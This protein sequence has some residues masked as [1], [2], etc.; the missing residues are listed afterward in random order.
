[1]ISFGSLLRNRH[2]PARRSIANLPHFHATN[3]EPITITSTSF[4]DGGRIPLRFSNVG[5]GDNVSPQLAWAGVPEN[6]KQLLLVVEDPDVPLPVPII[7]AAALFAPTGNSG[8][9]EE[10]ELSSRSS[11]FTFLPWLRATG[12][13]GPSPLKDQGPHHYGFYLFALDTVIN[14]KSFRQLKRKLSGHVLA[15]GVLT[16]VQSFGRD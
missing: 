16:G 1:M 6:A 8:S 7:H 14:A 4:P 11:R 3:P 10:G 12:Y 13:R 9:I 5:R 15:R 2:A